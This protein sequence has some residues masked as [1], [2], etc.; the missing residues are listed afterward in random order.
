MRSASKT[1][2][3]SESEV[4]VPNGE[5]EQLLQLQRDVLEMI[6]LGHA[7]DDILD[8]ICLLSEAMVPNSVGTIMLLDQTRRHLDVRSAPSIPAEG[9]AALNGLRPGPNAG[10]CGTA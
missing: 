5:L 8:Q 7:T 6:A 1:K 4:Q 9:I 3:T 2:T 10:S